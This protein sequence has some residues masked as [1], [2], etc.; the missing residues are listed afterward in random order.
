[1]DFSKLFTQTNE[2]KNS[3]S[4][5][6]SEDLQY[7]ARNSIYSILKVI[8]GVEVSRIQQ[9]YSDMKPSENTLGFVL[10]QFFCH[11]HVHTS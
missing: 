2:Q 5:V 11:L 3:V 7:P 1:M 8:Y 4:G 9:L 6:Q 10:K